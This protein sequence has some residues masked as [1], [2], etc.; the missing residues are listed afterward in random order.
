MAYS[1][2]KM[3]ESITITNKKKDSATK[4]YFDFDLLSDPIFLRICKG[5]SLRFAIITD[6]KVGLLYG[7][8]LVEFLKENELDAVLFTFSQGEEHKNRKTMEKIENEM[9]E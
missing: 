5:T 2:N 6:N 1:G 8:S 9:F 4:I 7:N 3:K